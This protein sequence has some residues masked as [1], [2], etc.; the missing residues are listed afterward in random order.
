MI[1]FLNGPSSAGKSMIAKAIQYL[2]ENPWLLIGIDTFFHMMPGQYVGF[3]AKADQGFH[4]IPDLDKEGPLMHIETG[5]V[6]RAVVEAAPKVVRTL[7]EASLDII[8]D[9][10]LLKEKN[11]ELYQEALCYQKVYFIGVMCDPMT[12]QEREILR[13]DR[14]LGLGR[15]QMKRVHPPSRQYDLTINTTTK[16]PFEC[17]REILK[18]IASNP[19][20][21]GFKKS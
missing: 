5:A 14:A 8:V 19:N 17:A 20:P 1:V 7:A 10:V 2:S 9:E 15:D 13:G 4:F 12:L 11:L 16:S 21:Q 18:F 3:G 6:G